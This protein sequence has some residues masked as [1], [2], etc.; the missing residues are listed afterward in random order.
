MPNHI[1]LLIRTLVSFS[2][3]VFIKK[4]NLSYYHYFKNKYDW[5][6]SFWQGRYKS[7]PVGKDEYFIQCGKYI[8][9]NPVRVNIVEN[10]EDY[11][12]SS[13]S[14]YTKEKSNDIITEDPFYSDLGKNK[15]ER[16]DNYK[17]IVV[18]DIIKESYNKSAWGSDIQRQRE[19]QKINRKIKK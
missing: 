16:Q 13:Y 11:F 5:T 2:F 18:A 9:L 4:I 3:S 8:E 14:Y 10:P 17:K 15:K 19:R 1:H 6:G 7:K 12:Y